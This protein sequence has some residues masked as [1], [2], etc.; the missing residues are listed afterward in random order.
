MSGGASRTKA[1]AP[2]ILSADNPVDAENDLCSAC[3]WIEES[4][5]DLDPSAHPEPMNGELC[6]Y[7]QRSARSMITDTGA[8]QCDAAAGCTAHRSVCRHARSE[9]R[10]PL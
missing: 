3:A 10:A 1:D 9:V 7:W 8:G 6:R 2:E 4:G 5:I